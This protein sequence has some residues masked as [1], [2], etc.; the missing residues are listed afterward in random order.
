MLD[1]HRVVT[2][3]LFRESCSP[4]KG[5]YVKDLSLMG[6]PMN[7]CIIID[8]SPYS[9]LFQ[10]ENAFPITSWFDD[11]NDTELLDIIPYLEKLA[12]CD[13]VTVTL[14]KFKKSKGFTFGKGLD[15]RESS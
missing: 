14:D 5:N 13:D 4:F 6:R 2:S 9:Y 8:N 3:R 11:P 1:P 10:P 7:S 12:T 15:R